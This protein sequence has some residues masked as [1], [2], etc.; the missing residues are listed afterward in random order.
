VRE[1]ALDLFD[2]L[3]P[4]HSVGGAHRELLGWAA[5]L[6]EIGL[7]LS[8]ES[9][10]RHSAYLVEASDMA[11]FSRQEQLFLAALG[12]FQRRDIPKDCAARLPRRLHEAL[13]LTLLCMRLSWIFCRTRETDTVPNFDIVLEG[14]QVHLALSTSWMENHPLTIADL[15][16][17]ETALQTIGL[18]L[19]TVYTD[20]EP[21]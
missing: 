7:G 2:Q 11:G 16:F 3:S 5:D 20:H 17:E 4:D 1:T 18:Q 8:H 14:D 13:S 12:G 19:K 9:Y 15:E 10:Q 21:N 6:H